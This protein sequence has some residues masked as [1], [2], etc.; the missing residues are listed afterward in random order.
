MHDGISTTESR[1]QF[2]KLMGVKSRKEEKSF[3]GSNFNEEEEGADQT[4]VKGITSHPIY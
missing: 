4:P 3:Y 1:M 2:K